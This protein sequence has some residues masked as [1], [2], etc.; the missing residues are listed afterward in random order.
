MSRGRKTRK[1]VKEARE[2]RKVTE[3]RKSRT[4]GR[5]EGSQVSKY[6]S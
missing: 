3:G 6:V 2:A 4:E 5:M 1:K